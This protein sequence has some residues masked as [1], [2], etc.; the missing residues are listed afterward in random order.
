LGLGRIDLT[1]RKSS[2]KTRRWGNI[3]KFHKKRG[4]G[5]EGPCLKTH[6][7]FPKKQKRISNPVGSI[8][9]WGEWEDSL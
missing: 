4:E 7:D 8:L 9:T 1:G 6:E 5:D 3:K 2:K